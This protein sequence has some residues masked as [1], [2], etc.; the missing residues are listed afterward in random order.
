MKLKLD[1]VKKVV[2]KRTLGLLAMA[3]FS[4]GM[5]VADVFD[6]DAT[7]KTLKAL[8]ERVSKLEGK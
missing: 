3:A 8:G 5:A 6:K 7:A 2:N 4:A 1:G